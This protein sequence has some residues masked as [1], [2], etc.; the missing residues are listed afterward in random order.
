VSDETKSARTDGSAEYLCLTCDTRFWAD[1]DHRVCPKCHSGSQVPRTDGKLEELLDAL[2]S[3][4]YRRG[5]DISHKATERLTA[6][7]KALRE[8]VAQRTLT[9]LEA[10]AV[11]AVGG[12]GRAEFGKPDDYEK[13]FRKLLLLSGS[14]PESQEIQK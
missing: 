11:L 14:A 9:P 1:P 2:E 13:G 8:H 10:K 6:A 3:A 12:F 5:H 7:R 4:A